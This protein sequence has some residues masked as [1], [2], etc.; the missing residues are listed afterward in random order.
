MKIEI[1]FTEVLAIWAAIVS[2]AV[3]VWNFVRGRRDRGRLK[4]RIEHAV[5]PGDGRRWL[6][7]TATNVG[8]RPI[9]AK[10][11]GA[12]ENHG[13]WFTLHRFDGN[14]PKK[15][16]EGEDI[17]DLVM[18]DH[19][20]SVALRNSTKFCVRDS[21]DRRWKARRK[22]LKDIKRSLMDAERS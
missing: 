10:S 7:F 14:L 22:N 20:L 21:R 4:V 16:E 19:D 17:T 12:K 3:M 6:G 9:S 13:G 18:L 15:L 8:R 1:K 5:I 2:T 11:W